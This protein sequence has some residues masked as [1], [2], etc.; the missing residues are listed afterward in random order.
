[1]SECRAVVNFC[2]NAVATLVVARWEGTLD[3]ERAR[4][5]FRGEIRM[6]EAALAD[7]DD[8][9]EG[10]ESTEALAG[11][12]SQGDTVVPA[13]PDASEEIFDE[14]IDRESSFA[15]AGRP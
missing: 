14:E 1:M 2:G 6:D 7:P 13:S 9:A 3:V 8:A 15:G 4:R 10:P 11:P 5:V 12:P